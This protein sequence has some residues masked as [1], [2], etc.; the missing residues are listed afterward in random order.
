M[1][2][3]DLKMRIM[4]DLEDKQV[5][6]DMNLSLIISLKRLFTVFYVKGARFRR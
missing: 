1:K 5:T 3:K 4:W 2:N 6:V